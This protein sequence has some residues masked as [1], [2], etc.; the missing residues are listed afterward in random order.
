MKYLLPLIF[1]CY[2]FSSCAT[3]LNGSKIRVNVYTP[4][5]ATIVTEDSTYTTNKNNKATIRLKRAKADAEISV[6]GHTVVLDS[7]L[8]AA[9]WLGLNYGFT[10]YGLL[11]P[12]IDFTNP[13]RHAYKRVLYM[14]STDSIPIFLHYR[15]QNRKGEIHGHFSGPY[16]FSH[17]Y[18]HPPNEIQPL[19]SGGIFG[20]RLG[21][22]YYHAPKQYFNLSAKISSNTIL[23]PRQKEM[24]GAY[25]NF[26]NHHKIKR[27]TLGYGINYSHIFLDIKKQTEPFVPTINP[28]SSQTNNLGLF[29][30][31]HYQTG[32][33]FYIGIDYRPT[34]I[35]MSDDSPA[36]YEH[37]IGLEFMWKIE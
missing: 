2:L 24:G 13:R 36:R 37:A 31:T 1:S 26:S 20:F 10:G 6:D 30:S 27:L 3:L 29:F 35:R 25:L 28:R 12:A 19:N 16:S 8:S 33:F 15:P 23:F 11:I 34:F 22:D 4:T 7:K 5:P 17:Y 21:V 18:I 9:F 14:V 32:G